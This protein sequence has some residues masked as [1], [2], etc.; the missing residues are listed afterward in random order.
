M[1]DRKQMPGEFKPGRCGFYLEKKRRYCR[2]VPNEGNKYCIEHSHLLGELKDQERIPCPLDPKHSCYKSK[3]KKHLKKCNAREKVQPAC[4][5]KSVNSG[6]GEDETETEKVTILTVPVEEVFQ[7]IE[8]VKNIHE[9]CQLLI[10]EEILEH[11]VMR[12][13]LSNKTYGEAALKHRRQQSSLVAHMQKLGLL[14]DG[15]CFVEF[16]AGKGALSHWVQLALPESKDNS[17]ILVDRGTARYKMDN[18]HNNKEEGPIFERLRMD[19][20][21]LC[22]SKVPTVIDH[23]RAVVGMSKHLCGAATDLT[24]RC[25]VGS[26]KCEKECT[27][28]LGHVNKKQKVDESTKPNEKQENSWIEGIII[29]LCCHHR[30]SWTHFVGK[31]FFTQHGLTGRD[32]QLVTSM[33]SW[34]T[35]GYRP[36]KKGVDLTLR[37]MV[38]SN[39]YKKECTG[40]LG[41]VNKK[42]KVDESTKPNEKQENSWIEGIIIALCCHHRCSWTHFVGKD[43]FTQHGLTGRDFQLVTSMSSW[44]TCGYRPN[45]KGVEKSSSAQEPSKAP[46]PYSSLD[47]NLVKIENKTLVEENMPDQSET[48]SCQS[49]MKQ[50]NHDKHIDEHNSDDGGEHAKNEDS[51]YN[52]PR[53]G[54]LTPKQRED[55]GK[56]CK[57]LIDLGRMHYL[58]QKGFQTQLMVYIPHTVSL[59]NVVLTAVPLDRFGAM[60]AEGNSLQ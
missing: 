30:C 24:L 39:K 26:N 9:K 21:H 2:A 29:A 58:K 17:Y 53:Y 38:G 12:E 8:K 1:A 14:K 33:S 35:C 23:P 5:Q 43:F 27:G 45:K 6:Y 15:T 59:E 10:Q 50:K 54:A 28:D 41:H 60:L 47:Q 18:Y 40:D 46:T 16:G 55:I 22:L 13:E 34:A 56:Q 51:G 44:A 3:L 20:E 11:P 48:S 37:C 7:L 19:I 32:F 4:Y 42:Q 57:R 49:D 36:N 52:H 31:D 25:M